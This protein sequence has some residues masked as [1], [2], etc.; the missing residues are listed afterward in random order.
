[1]RPNKWYL[2][3]SLVCIF[4]GTSLILITPISNIVIKQMTR[5]ALHTTVNRTSKSKASFNFKKVKSIDTI[6]V[7]KGFF[8]QARVI[9]IISIPAI[10]LKLPIYQG[11]NNVNLVKG[12]GT[13]KPNQKMGKRNY[14]LAGHHMTNPHIL[15]SPLQNIKTGNT[16]YLINKS[17]KVYSYRVTTKKIISKYQTSYIKDVGQKKMITLITCA[18][19]KPG[20]TRR[21]MVRGILN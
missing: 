13:M 6:S 11:I 14:T 12:A 5:T 2:L 19:G 20:E 15:F 1:L 4:L 9:G 7:V 3:F 18:S 21:I 8:N 17:K 10:K 16:I